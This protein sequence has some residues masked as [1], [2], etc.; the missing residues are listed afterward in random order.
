MKTMWG[1]R[2]RPPV[3]LREDR[4]LEDPAQRHPDLEVRPTTLPAP[5]NQADPLPNSGVRTKQRMEPRSELEWKLRVTMVCRICYGARRARR[6]D[7]VSTSVPLVRFPKC[8]VRDGGAEL[9]ARRGFLPAD[10]QRFV[11][12]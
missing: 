11:F 8:C 3:P 10:R 6:S 5:Q 2:P 12:C 7:H 4:V 9:P 1:G